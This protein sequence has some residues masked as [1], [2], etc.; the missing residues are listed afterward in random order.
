MMKPRENFAC[1]VAVVSAT[2]VSTV[3]ASVSIKYYRMA[4]KQC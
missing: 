3:V 1:I 2:V 4:A